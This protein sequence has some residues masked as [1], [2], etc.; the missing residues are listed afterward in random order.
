M[1]ITHETNQLD[2]KECSNCK[3][4]NHNDESDLCYYCFR[5]PCSSHSNFEDNWY[6]KDGKL[7]ECKKQ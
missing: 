2:E 7:W 3:H 4:K 5:L 1:N 6:P